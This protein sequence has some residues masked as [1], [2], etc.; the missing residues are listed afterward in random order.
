MMFSPSLACADQLNLERDVEA[1][2][3]CPVDMMHIDIMDGHYVPNLSLNPQLCRDLKRK[4]PD[5]V[6]DVHLMVTNPMDYIESLGGMG[7]DWFTFQL[8]ST[9]FLHRTISAVKKTGM[10]VGIAINPGESLVLLEPI[11]DMVDMILLMA[12]EPGFSGQPFIAAT[13]D[14]IKHLNSLRMARNLQFKINVDGGL[15]AD[16]GR[17]CLDA[18]ADILVLG[19]FACFNQPEGI[20]PSFR[21]F[22]RRLE[23]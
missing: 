21:E 19:M 15:N 23:G 9:H 3:D 2:R 7:V 22:C 12:I 20:I 4:Y 17:R 5:M 18:G 10:K 1:L 6:L 8:S 14:R 11:I 16:I 13:Y